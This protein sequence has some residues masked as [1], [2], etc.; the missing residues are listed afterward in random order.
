VKIAIGAIGPEDAALLQIGFP[1]LSDESRRLAVPDPMQQ[2]DS[3]LVEYLTRNRP[4]RPRG[5]WRLRTAGE[6]VGVARYVQPV[7]DPEAADVAV[8]VIDAWQGRGL[9]PPC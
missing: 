8:A 1:A 2:L 6:P 9:R 5:A 4:L 7:D 3:A